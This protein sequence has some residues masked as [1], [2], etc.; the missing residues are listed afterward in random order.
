MSSSWPG[1]SPLTARAP[2]NGAAE[3]GWRVSG[4]CGEMGAVQV[5]DRAVSQP[6]LSASCRTASAYRDGADFHIII[7]TSSLYPYRVCLPYV[8]CQY[9]DVFS[10]FY[11]ITKSKTGF[12]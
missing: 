4:H 8:K 1:E 3:A 2:G 6:Q 10:T 7:F 12:H 11:L 5:S 9:S